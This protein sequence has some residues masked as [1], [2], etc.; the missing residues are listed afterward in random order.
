M[1]IIKSKSYEKDYKSKIVKLH[2]YKEMERISNI[3]ELILDS[4]NLKKVIENPLSIIYGIKKKKGDLKEI[5]TAKV[6]DKIRLYMKPVG[7]Y[8]YNLIKIESI[9]FIKIDD[10]HYGEG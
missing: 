2:K 4:K 1:K 5:Y 8:P 10:K 7:K 3:E 9:D 6:N